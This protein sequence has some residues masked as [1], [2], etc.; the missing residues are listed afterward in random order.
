MIP[1]K[2]CS[3]VVSNA[4]QPISVYETTGT[5]GNGLW[6]PVK[7]TARTIM[8]DVFNADPQ[9]VQILTGGD[10]SD[11]GLAIQ[12]METLYFQD[13]KITT[14]ENKQSFITYEGYLYKVIAK[15]F[16]NINAGFDTY[17]ATRYL[18]HG[19]DS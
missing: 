6:V 7:G 19:S 10:V 15:G 9:K 13:P 1:L 3:K 2:L 8:A 17:I 11:G 4:S 12:T 16:Q 14:T 5:R 18:E